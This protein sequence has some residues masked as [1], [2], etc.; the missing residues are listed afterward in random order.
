MNNELT[1]SPNNNTKFT[2]YYIIYF[3]ALEQTFLITE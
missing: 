2:R 3:L 1:P